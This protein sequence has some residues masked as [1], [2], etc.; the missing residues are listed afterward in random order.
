MLSACSNQPAGDKSPGA[1]LTPYTTAVTAYS[2]PAPTSSDP[3]PLPGPSPTPF[4]Y[5]IQAGDT[6][7]GVALR[8]G[9]DLAVLLAANPG[10]NPNAISIG[11]EILIPPRGVNNAQSGLGTGVPIQVSQPVCYSEGAGGMWCFTLLSNRTEGAAEG[12]IVKIITANA[13]MSQLSEQ[14]AA[15]LLNVM[16][17]GADLPAAV[18]FPPPAALPQRTSAE[19]V[20]S[21]PLADPNSRYPAS[22]IRD[23]KVTIHPSGK[24]AAVT[25]FIRLEDAQANATRV[26]VLAAAFDEQGSLV[27]VRRWENASGI[28]AGQEIPFEMQVYSSAAH[29]ARVSLY[30]EAQK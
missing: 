30:V 8:Y 13:D 20:S 1:R 16:R 15:T 14:S 4:Y 27:G 5:K 24:S 25:G 6:L 22:I 10:V 17:A 12:L 18:Y 29:I 3:T 21:L 26:W 11:T 28:S 9:V 23:E 19:V 7:S 2:T